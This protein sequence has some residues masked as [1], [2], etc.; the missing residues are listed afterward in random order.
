MNNCGSDDD[1]ERECVD[2]VV[3]RIWAIWAVMMLVDGGGGGML[4]HKI[5]CTIHRPTP[6]SHH[7]MSGCVEMQFTWDLIDSNIR[8]SGKWL[9]TDRLVVVLG[10]A[11]SCAWALCCTAAARCWS[12][13][14]CLPKVHKQSQTQTP[15]TNLSV[16]ETK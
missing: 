10:A 4:A 5:L 14:V 12:F 11:V 15:H 8:V 9:Y 7:A 13:G 1:G 6:H 2:E 3:L 16:W